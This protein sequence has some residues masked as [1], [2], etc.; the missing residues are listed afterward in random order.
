[1][2]DGRL[3]R[4]ARSGR[5]PAPLGLF[6]V[7]FGAGVVGSLAMTI[8]MALVRGFRLSALNFEMVLGTL[9]NGTPGPGAWSLGWI[10]HLVN[11]GVFALLYAA[12]FRATGRWGAGAGAVFGIFHW[13]IA[14]IVLGLLPMFHPLIPA[15]MAPPGYFALD[16]GAGAFIILLAEHLIYGAI[17]GA[18]CYRSAIVA[19]GGREARETPETRRAA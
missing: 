14:G 8:L 16:L 18:L 4:A 5:S 6:G 11:G 1:M 13:V 7:A 3:N 2:T 15:V 10:W 9:L 12:A 17:V 19:T